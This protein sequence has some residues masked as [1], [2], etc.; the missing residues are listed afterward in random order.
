MVGRALG[1]APAAD[2]GPSCG[3]CSGLAVPIAAVRLARGRRRPR[4]VVPAAERSSRE[5][6]TSGS[7][8]CRPPTSC[9]AR[10]GD[11][12]RASMADVELLELFTSHLAPPLVVAFVVPVLALI[13]LLVVDPSLAVVVLPFVLAAPACRPGCCA[14][15]R[16]RESGCASELG[17]PGR[18]RGRRGAGDPRDPRRERRGRD[19]RPRR[20]AARADPADEHRARAPL[21]DRTRR[22][23]R[24]HGARRDRGVAA[25]AALTARGSLDPRGSRWR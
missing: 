5:R 3:S 21:G 2:L 7:A 25:T 4:D 12:A 17:R 22:D 8:C 20:G 16:T 18:E 23:R 6:C 14:A 19:A 1:G 24:D 11:V 13:G 15:P 9:I 10:S